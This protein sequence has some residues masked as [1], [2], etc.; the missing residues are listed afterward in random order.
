MKYFDLINIYFLCSCKQLAKSA[1]GANLYGIPLYSPP[2]TSCHNNVNIRILILV[3]GVCVSLLLI[4]LIV[5]AV[6]R[7]Y[8][9]TRPRIK[10]TFV[11][12]KKV[13]QTPLTSRPISTEQ[14]EITI[15]NCCNMNICE[16]V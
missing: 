4:F 11:V 3:I 14:C 7:F 16:T 15:E 1:D 10:K 13:S 6:R 8:K 12:Q 9:P 2:E 5:H